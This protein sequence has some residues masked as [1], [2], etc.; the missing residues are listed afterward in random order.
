MTN[1]RSLVGIGQQ[2][3][4]LGQRLHVEVLGEAQAVAAGLQ[5][6]RMAF[7]KASL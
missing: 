6:L 2:R 7:W 4:Q 1:W 5:R 3:K